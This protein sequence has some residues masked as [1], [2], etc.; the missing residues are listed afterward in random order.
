M[1]PQLYISFLSNN[2]AWK[3][4]NTKQ[5]VDERNNG[6]DDIIY[7]FDVSVFDMVRMWS[8]DLVLTKDNNG[9]KKMKILSHISEQ[10]DWDYT[11]L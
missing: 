4:G 1:L 3:N 6:E 9:D 5:A 8:T 2:M 10:L 11:G 7:E